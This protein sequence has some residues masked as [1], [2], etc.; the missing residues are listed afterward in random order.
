MPHRYIP[1]MRSFARQRITTLLALFLLLPTSFAQST[2][3]ALDWYRKV[4]SWE[5]QYRAT[6]HQ[7]YLQ[8]GMQGRPP[9]LDGVDPEVREKL[10]EVSQAAAALWSEGMSLE[11]AVPPPIPSQRALVERRR[12]IEAGNRGL[13]AAVQLATTLLLDNIP[14]SELIALNTSLEHSFEIRDLWAHLYATTLKE[15]AER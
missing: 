15:G 5:D 6:Y 1:G 3:P 9:G 14:K 4:F 13:R 7:L 12:M 11:G 2:D 8:Y 10:L